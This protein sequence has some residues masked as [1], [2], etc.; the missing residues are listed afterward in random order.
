[1]QSSAL[2]KAQETAALRNFDPA[3]DRFGSFTIEEVEAARPSMSALHPKRTSG[4]TRRY[5]RF[6]PKAD[7]GQYSISS[8][9]PR[10]SENYQASEGPDRYDRYA[11]RYFI[12]ALIT[13]ST[14]SPERL[15]TACK[16]VTS[17]A[18]RQPRLR[19]TIVNEPRY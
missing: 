1:M 12:A 16:H 7:I 4:E 13:K 6:V 8:S 18:H 3:Y 19:H 14:K 5:V 15:R 9:A 11:N 17:F 10:P 2:L